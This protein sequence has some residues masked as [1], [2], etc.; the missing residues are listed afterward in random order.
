MIM[1]SHTSAR[2]Y[3]HTQT[4]QREATGGVAVAPVK[5]YSSSK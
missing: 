5:I 2:T 4:W 3:T 1:I